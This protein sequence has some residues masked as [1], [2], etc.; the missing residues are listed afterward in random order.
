MFPNKPEL[1]MNEG[2]LRHQG[3]RLETPNILYWEGDNFPFPPSSL[4]LLQDRVERF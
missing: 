4:S 3:N 2:Y 1:E